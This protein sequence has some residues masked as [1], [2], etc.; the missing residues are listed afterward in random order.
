MDILFPPSLRVSRA[1]WD[2][3]SNTAAARSIFTGAVRTTSRTG[4]RWR[5]S[6][7]IANASNRVSALE[8][9]QLRTLRALLR[10]QANRIYFADP[11]YVLRGSFPTSELVVN[12]DFANGTTGWTA[13]S[14]SDT[15]T[16]TA[17]DGHARLKRTG[18]AAGYYLS[19]AVT[20]ING[21]SYA[22][23]SFFDRGSD[24]SPAF[25][26]QIDST[27]GATVN[28]TGLSIAVKTAASTSMTAKPWAPNAGT[29]G[30][31]FE[32]TWVSMARCALVNGGGQ[33]SADLYLKALP[34]STNGLLL[35]DDRVQ[36]N[37]ELLPVR[38]AL[39]SDGSGYGYL[40]LV[41][42]PRTIPADGD[43]VIIHQPMGRFV[44]AEPNGG[45]DDMPGGFSDFEFTL[46]ESLDA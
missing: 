34:L 8:R 20:V 42:P 24:A 13:G 39:N 40:P 33:T 46:E 17:S 27:S 7:T 21:A 22:C 1:H 43:T 36:I 30:R 28:D 31:H 44:L 45:W 11:S 35:K 6:F 23:R 29:S 2:Y 19:Q 5:V 41:R 26:S 9:M 15:P 4:D 12:G 25:A 37:N 14:A 10:G 32:I 18:T 16:L 3:V 38:S